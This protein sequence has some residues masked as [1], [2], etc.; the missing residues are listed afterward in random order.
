MAPA[1][2]FRSRI[3]AAA[4]AFGLL[5]GLGCGGGKS[6]QGGPKPVAVI[7]GT[8]TYTRP[9]LTFDVNGVPTGLD[10][11]PANLLTLP[12][13]GVS[14]R[15]YQRDDSGSSP[16]WVL[17]KNAFTDATGK[18]FMQ[19]APGNNYLVQVESELKPG[20]NLLSLIADPNGLSSTVP[21]I[22]RARYLLRAS[23]SGTPATPSDLTPVQSIAGNGVYNSNIAIDGTTQWLVGSNEINSDGSSTAF[24]SAAF[25]SSPSGSRI[26]A[27]LD[28][29]A[30]FGITYGDPTPGVPLDLHYLVGR[31]EPAGTYIEYRPLQWVL[32]GGLDLAYDTRT[33]SDHFFGSIQGGPAN[34]DAFDASVIYRLLG[35]SFSYHLNTARSFY[36]QAPNAILPVGAPLDGLSPEQA[37]EEGMPLALAANLLQ[38]PYLADTD[39]TSSLI[40]PPLDIRDL[41]AV[42]PADQ[43]PYSPRTLAA[44]VWEIVLKANGITSP[45]TATDW[46]T[47]QPK[48][49]VRIF[50]LTAPT[51]SITTGTTTTTQKLFAPLNIYTQLGLLQKPKS[52]TEPVNLAGIFDDTTLNTITSPFN[53]PWPQPT[54]T[55]FGQAW[56]SSAVNGPY[57]YSGT[58]SMSAD[59]QQVN[60]VYPNASYQEIA[61]LGI[62]QATDQAYNLTLQTTPSPLPAGATIQVVVFS[63]ATTQAYTFTGTSAS[64][65][66]F[67]LA[68]NGNTTT[69]AQY[70]IMVRLLSPTTVQPD[71]PFTLTLAPA[72]PGSL[73]GPVLRF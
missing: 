43:G 51:V 36:G 40:S 63:G 10:T 69:P 4:A 47:I 66:T 16:R 35:K 18:F 5:F 56:T 19:L 61:Y 68:G 3:A 22:E 60:G 55:L 29:A 45:G 70:P 14:V 23:P 27:I 17:R 30:Q 42:A 64:P 50:N 32:P 37:L 34:D 73:R 52:T 1:P 9:P 65:I 24:A 44:M 26:A 6:G 7:K 13:P 62:P 71:I 39:G 46:A 38:S 15:A 31:S 11:N 8:I 33:D 20:N 28:S 57:T 59:Q 67:T 53:L 2:S 21:Q 58:L 72:P 54:T 49:M 41:S 48:A 25:E 12:L